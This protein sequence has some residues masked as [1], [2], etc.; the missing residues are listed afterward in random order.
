MLARLQVGTRAYLKNFRKGL[1]FQ[2][3]KCTSLLENA[4]A[5]GDDSEAA[6][7]QHRLDWIFAKQRYLDVGH[8][9]VLDKPSWQHGRALEYGG[10][11]EDAMTSMSAREIAEERIKDI[12]V[13]RLYLL[14]LIP[15][16]MP[17]ACHK[18][19]QSRFFF[20]AL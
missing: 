15:C 10:L 18:E 14:S 11:Q 16:G 5:R 19:S 13:E 4:T 3:S 12:A 7:L 1:K 9:M 8:V 6:E 17:M 2:V 20:L